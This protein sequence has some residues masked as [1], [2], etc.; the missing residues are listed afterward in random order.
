LFHLNKC[1]LKNL[2]YLYCV[3][4]FFSCGDGHES[5]IDKPQQELV[6]KEVELDTL[7]TQQQIIHNIDSVYGITKLGT[8]D[9]IPIE[10]YFFVDT[11]IKADFTN[12]GIRDYFIRTL[13]G[14]WPLYMGHFYDG[15]SGNEFMV[16]STFGMFPMSRFSMPFRLISSPDSNCSPSILT[17]TTVSMSEGQMVDL[18]N[19]NPRT[20]QIEKTFTIFTANGDDYSNPPVGSICFSNIYRENISCNDTIKVFE[21]KYINPNEG[22]SYEN[23][24]RL[25]SEEDSS[26]AFNNASF[27]WE[28][29][30]FD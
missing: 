24:T 18:F 23:V 13:A 11:I 26:Y 21:G 3:I 19:Y 15:K 17:S 10:D 30:K 7:Q 14:G 16:D 6:K 9:S 12:D 4:I 20:N 22:D 25:G 2:T 28:K 27:R 5:I 8:E 1:A 29:V